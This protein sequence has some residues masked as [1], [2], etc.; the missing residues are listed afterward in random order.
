MHNDLITLNPIGYVKTNVAD[1]DIPRQR[2][3]ILSEL[4]ILDDYSEA[5]EGIEAYSHLFVLFWMHQVA[6]QDYRAKVHPRGR[7]DLPLTG[8]LATR[9]RAHPNPIGLAVVEL[10]ERHANRLKVRRLDAYHGTPIL[11]LK[12]YD[13]YDQVQDIRVPD[14]WARLRPQR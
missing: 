13:P 12:P 5:L 4:V 3:Q 10:L 1:A 14:W 6:M 8:V 9:A 2:A 7:D 11:D